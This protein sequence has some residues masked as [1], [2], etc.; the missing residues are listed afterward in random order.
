MSDSAHRTVDI[1]ES[2]S[3]LYL[4]NQGGFQFNI[5]KSVLDSKGN[6][7]YNMVW[8]SQFLA[9]KMTFDWTVQYALNWT[10]AIPGLG[11]TVTMGGFWKDTNPGDVWDIDEYGIF[12]PTKTGKKME[13][14]LKIGE[15]RRAP[16]A[17]QNGIHIVV[18]IKTGNS[19]SPVSTKQRSFQVF[20]D[21]DLG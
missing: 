5:A 16:V 2:Q 6:L 13:G 7:S 12:V 8:Q 3:D 4:L 17:G 20:N 9:P 14:Y 18:G 19:Y 15:N 1:W 11:L 10:N 21:V